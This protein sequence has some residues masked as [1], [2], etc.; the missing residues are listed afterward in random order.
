MKNWTHPG[1]GCRGT[2][3]QEQSR[4][5]QIRILHQPSQL[6]FRHARERG[7]ESSN[8]RA[9]ERLDTVE[10]DRRRHLH[11]LFGD[12]GVSAFASSRSKLRSNLLGDGLHLRHQFVH[13]PIRR[14]NH[15]LCR[16]S[17][18]VSPRIVCDL[19]SS[20]SFPH[21]VRSPSPSFLY[22]FS[23]STFW[24]VRRS[25]RLKTTRNFVEGDV[26]CIRS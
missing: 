16:T 25:S 9:P 18:L 3:V 19:V 15:N 2:W 6:D 11:A 24:P 8:R 17:F 22:P 26:E 12:N 23:F 5:P 20:F 1:S 21:Q 7:S 4:D 13:L 10:Y 14:S